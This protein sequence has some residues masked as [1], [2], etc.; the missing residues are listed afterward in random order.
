MLIP[1]F[2]ESAFF[3]RPMASRLALIVSA[4]ALPQRM[5]CSSRTHKS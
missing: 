3:E 4:I 2:W 1:A 5:I